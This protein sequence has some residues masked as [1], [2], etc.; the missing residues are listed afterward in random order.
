[1]PQR[2]IN[3]SDVDALTLLLNLRGHDSIHD[4]TSNEDRWEKNYT[5]V[6]EFGTL[7]T[8]IKNGG[9]GMPLA[10]K[11]RLEKQ[12]AKQRAQQ[13]RE[14]KA[15]EEA[16]YRF[17]ITNKQFRADVAMSLCCEE[18]KIDLVFILFDIFI[19]ILQVIN[20]SGKRE[21]GEGPLFMGPNAQKLTSLDLIYALQRYIDYKRTKYLNIFLTNPFS[22]GEREYNINYNDKIYILVSIIQK[23]QIL[24]RREKWSAEKN[25]MEWFEFIF[26]N[27]DDDLFKISIVENS[28]TLQKKLEALSVG[29]AKGKY[30]EDRKITFEE[31]TDITSKCNNYLERETVKQQFDDL[32]RLWNKHNASLGIGAGQALTLQ[33]HNSFRDIRKEILTSFKGIFLEKELVGKAGAIDGGIDGSLFLPVLRDRVQ[34][35]AFDIFVTFV[36]KLNIILLDIQKIVDF[37]MFETYKKQQKILKDSIAAAT[38]NLGSEEKN[39]RKMFIQ[40]VAKSA[41]MSTNVCDITGKV[42]LTAAQKADIFLSKQINILKKQADWQVE[43][44]TTKELDAEIINLAKQFLNHTTSNAQLYIHWIKELGILFRYIVNNASMMRASAREKYVFCPT[45]SVADGMSQCPISDPYREWGNMNFRVGSDKYWI[46]GKLTQLEMSKGQF[47]LKTVVNA[48]I[49]GGFLVDG[50]KTIETKTDNISLDAPVLEAHHVLKN[51]LTHLLDIYNDVMKDDPMRTFFTNLLHYMLKNNDYS[52]IFK[53]LLGKVIGDFFQEINCVCKHGG[54]ESLPTYD[55]SIAPWVDGNAKRLFLANDRPSAFRFAFLVSKG[56]ASDINNDAWGGYLS[57]HDELIWSR[58]GAAVGVG[59][60]GKSKKKTQMI[61]NPTGQR[62]K[63]KTQMIQNPIRQRS[64]KQKRSMRNTQ[65]RR[66]IIK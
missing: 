37:T 24:V 62:S 12:R 35:G 16:S 1:M 15:R 47:E 19:N 9:H 21:L 10:E 26:K 41:L 38:G 55:E 50:V 40:C 4:Y 46:E 59:A 3:L 54:Y 48:T 53:D 2:E 64:K 66:N 39:T 43:D 30:K 60:G 6:K 13:I 27:C 32:Q 25:M 8:I 29:G 22:V 45:S 49:V 17:T 7:N 57:S 63:K 33:E 14:K 52:P 65:R 23:I 36:K 11:K 61:Q 5:I 34:R 20:N 31:A 42:K 51:S 56:L 18:L 28:W 44:W 58:P